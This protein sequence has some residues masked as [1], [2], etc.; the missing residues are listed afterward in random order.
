MTVQSFLKFNL[1]GLLLAVETKIVREII[2][3]PELTIIEECPSY[4]A[5]VANMHGK[6]VP[7]MDLNIRFG[8]P[9]QRYGCAD[10]VI[11]LDVSALCNTHST[12]SMLGI[13]VNDVLD[14]MD[15]PEKDIELP[16]FEGREIK[17]HPNFVCGVAKAEQNIIMMLNLRAMI[18]SEFDIREPEH[19]EPEI[20]SQRP[21]SYFCPEAD[22]G[23]KEIFHNRST[24][25]QQAVDREDTNRLLPVAVLSLNKE[26]LCVELESVREFSK[27]RTITPVPCCPEHITGNMNLRGNVLTVVDIRGLLNM[28]GG[29]ISDTAKVIVADSGGYPVGVVVDEILDVINLSEMDIVPVPPSMRAL[30]EKFVKGAAPYGSKMMAL[31]D[32][33]EILSWDGLVVNE[34]V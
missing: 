17:P 34:E 31:L 33:D 30:E 10:R 11:L 18:D 26:C 12:H 21:L 32:L 5:G 14:V 16:P 22:Q 23:E 8:H 27:I 19:D 28:Q 25:L 13:I 1:H 4:I 7:V 9:P 20:C 6:V 15:I 29:R 3:L 2:W 24:I